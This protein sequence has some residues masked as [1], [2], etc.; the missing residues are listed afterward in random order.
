VRQQHGLVEP[1]ENLFHITIRIITVHYGSRFKE[2]FQ[3][4]F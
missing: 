3:E 2:K 1:E 4:V